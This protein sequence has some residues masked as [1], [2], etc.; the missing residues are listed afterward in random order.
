MSI[1]TLLNCIY[2]YVRLSSNPWFA[3]AS[4]WAFTKIL[5][6]S[7][8]FILFEDERGAYYPTPPLEPSHATS[9]DADRA[10]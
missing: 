8:L 9:E 2:I 4:R 10:D 7:C 1:L 3:S 5:V 6:S